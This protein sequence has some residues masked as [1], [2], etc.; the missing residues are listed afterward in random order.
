MKF[1]FAKAARI[2][3]NFMLVGDEARIEW[4]KSIRFFPVSLVTHAKG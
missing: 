3:S 1:I 4:D 2:L